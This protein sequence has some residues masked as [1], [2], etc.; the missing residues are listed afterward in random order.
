M[1]MVESHAYVILF[2]IKSMEILSAYVDIKD[3]VE[4]LHSDSLFKATLQLLRLSANDGSAFYT[5]LGTT[6]KDWPVTDVGIQNPST[7]PCR[8]SL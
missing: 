5:S 6:S 1:Q 2:F 3:I 7:L 8:V 4:F